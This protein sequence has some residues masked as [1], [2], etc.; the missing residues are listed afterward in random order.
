LLAV[1]GSPGIAA[2]ALNSVGATPNRIREI[3]E[4]MDC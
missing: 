1:A 3:I 4:R 2:T